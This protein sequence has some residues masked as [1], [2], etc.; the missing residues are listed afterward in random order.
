LIAA[1]KAK[2]MVFH[3]EESQ[4]EHQEHLGL[5]VEERKTVQTPVQPLSLG[6][7]LLAQS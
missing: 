7:F 5:K 3:Q 6:Q 1:L 2:E 4:L